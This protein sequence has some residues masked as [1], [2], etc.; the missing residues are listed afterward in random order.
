ML[1]I[2]LYERVTDTERDRKERE[3]EITKAGKQS[4]K[5]KTRGR[6]SGKR[7]ICYPRKA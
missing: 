5:L 7:I 1:Y 3:R 4:V 2:L 6:P